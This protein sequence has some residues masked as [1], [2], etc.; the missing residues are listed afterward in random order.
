MDLRLGSTE[1]VH[2]PMLITYTQYK[3][4]GG[5]KPFGKSKKL[6]RLDV[7]FSALSEIARAKTNREMMQKWLR[8]KHS[9]ISGKYLDAHGP[10]PGVSA[11]VDRN[12][13]TETPTLL[14]HSWIE[15]NS[16]R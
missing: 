10:H 3:L 6:V 13:R 8:N 14:L 15:Y 4:A 7:C 5:V 12:A 9:L 2:T 1:G 11:R 16:Q